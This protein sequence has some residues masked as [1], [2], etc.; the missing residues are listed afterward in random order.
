MKQKMPLKTLGSEEHNHPR[1]WEVIFHQE[2]EPEFWIF[3]KPVRVELAASMI[4]L[5]EK[6]PLLGRPQVDTLKGSRYPNVKELR[7]VANG[8]P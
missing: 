6:G 5:R 4:I 3:P 7:L 1:Q 8:E 2:F